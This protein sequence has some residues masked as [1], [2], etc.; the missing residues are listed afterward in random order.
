M[1]KAARVCRCTGPFTRCPTNCL[2]AAIA[3]MSLAAFSRACKGSSLGGALRTAR[4]RSTGAA[5]ALPETPTAKSFMEREAKFGAHNYHPLPSESAINAL[6]LLFLFL[7]FRS[8]LLPCF[9]RHPQLSLPAPKAFLCGMW[10]NG[11]TL[12]SSARTP[13]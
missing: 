11:N 4:F 6:P 13:L 9:H 10:T 2:F 7:S 12:T 8:L 5:Q 1:S 3:A